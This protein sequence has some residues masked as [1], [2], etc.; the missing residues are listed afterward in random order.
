MNQ[1]LLGLICVATLQIF[2]V[3]ADQVVINE[4]MY[5][6]S[7]AIP[8]DSGQEW[9]ELYNKG[10][11][12]VNLNGWALKRSVSLTFTNRTIP[13]GGYLVVAANTNIFASRYPG[14]SNVAG[15][16]VG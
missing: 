9:I 2:P 7:P 3:L 10:T 15:N 14:V 5:H 8:E 6:P 16:W 4:I 13:A 11:N 1:K 12:S